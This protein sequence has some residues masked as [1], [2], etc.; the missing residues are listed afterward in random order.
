MGRRCE[1]VDECETG[2]A[3]C[4]ESGGGRCVNEPGSFRCV[5]PAGAEFDQS[6]RRCEDVDECVVLGEEEACPGNG[7]LGHF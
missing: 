5:C 4:G 6:S 1:D 2:E 3:D 7:R